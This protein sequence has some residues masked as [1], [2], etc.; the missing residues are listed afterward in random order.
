MGLK[1]YDLLLLLVFILQIASSFLI[2]MTLVAIV[3]G[4]HYTDCHI[5]TPLDTGSLRPRNDVCFWQLFVFILQIASSFLIA[6]TL[7]AIVYGNHYTDCHIST[8]LDT[9]SLR[10]RNDISFWQLF[11]FIFTDCHVL[12]PRNDVSSHRF[13]VIN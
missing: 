6:M 5:S 1:V 10:P 2:A 3:Y 11:V 8:P 13:A 4:N 9:G 7:V 12:R